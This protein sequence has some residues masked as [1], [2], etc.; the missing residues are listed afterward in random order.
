MALGV[1]DY[2]AADPGELQFEPLST[3]FNGKKPEI[4]ALY[5]GFETLKE[6]RRKDVLRFYEDFWEMIDDERAFDR[7]ILR[8]CKNW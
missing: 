5:E 1:G 2:Q 6:D 3:F 8:N 4:I 7:Q